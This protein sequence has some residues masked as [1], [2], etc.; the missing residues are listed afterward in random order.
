MKRVSY[1]PPARRRW[2]SFDET[3]GTS[4][5]GKNDRITPQTITKAIAPIAICRTVR[6]TYFESTGVRWTTEVSDIEETISP[7]LRHA[8]QLQSAQD[9]NERACA[10]WRRSRVRSRGV[11]RPATRWITCSTG[12]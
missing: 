8:D 10:Q 7:W 3:S 2:S 1:E 9:R 6:R 4:W 11:G 12:A 5:K